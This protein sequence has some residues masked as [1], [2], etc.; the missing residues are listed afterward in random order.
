MPAKLFTIFYPDYVINFRII[1]SWRHVAKNKKKLH[2][3]TD[4]VLIT[5]LASA[6][7]ERLVVRTS[8]PAGRQH[9]RLMF[10]PFSRRVTAAA[11]PSRKITGAKRQQCPEC[12]EISEHYF[13]FFTVSFGTDLLMSECIFIRYTLDIEILGFTCSRHRQTFSPCANELFSLVNPV[14]KPWFRRVPW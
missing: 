2:V 12:I 8:R 13:F 10:G 11:Y 5:A 4:K 1:I 9:Q 3:I 7:A 14:P 6:D